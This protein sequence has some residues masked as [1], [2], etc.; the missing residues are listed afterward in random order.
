[1]LQIRKESFVTFIIC[2]LK[3]VCKRLLFFNGGYIEKIVEKIL[4]NQEF[5]S[6]N[7][8]EI[9]L[10]SSLNEGHLDLDY[11]IFSL[12]YKPLPSRELSNSLDF[13]CSF[14]IFLCIK[15]ILLMI[16]AKTKSSTFVQGLQRVCGW[17]KQTSRQIEWTLELRLRKAASCCPLASGVSRVMGSPACSQAGDKRPQPR[18]LGWHRG[19]FVPIFIGGRMVFLR[20]L[21]SYRHFCGSLFCLLIH[22]RRNIYE[23]H[24]F[25]HPAERHS[26]TGE[27]YR[28]HEAIR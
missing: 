28:C 8:F 27:L 6:F 13:F 10:N 14:G 16:K 21:R 22:P 24:F 5:A 19:P 17:W 26:Y 7:F 11:S 15:P 12:F 2:I 9:F 25:R 23:N 18:H 4:L 1:M 20:S 3:L